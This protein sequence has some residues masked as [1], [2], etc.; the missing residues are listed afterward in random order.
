ME[1]W[2]DIETSHLQAIETVTS[3]RARFGN[4]KDRWPSTVDPAEVEA[5]D[6]A[7]WGLSYRPAELRPADEE[8]REW[9]RLA[10]ALNT[11]VDRGRFAI[12]DLQQ[13]AAISESLGDLSMSADTHRRLVDEYFVASD[14]Q[15]IDSMMLTARLDIA[16]GMWREA[17]DSANTALASALASRDAARL[18]QCYR[19]FSELYRELGTADQARI[20]QLEQARSAMDLGDASQILAAEIEGIRVDLAGP[21][22][23]AVPTRLRKLLD[24]ED[25]RNNSRLHREL[26]YLSLLA[27]GRALDFGDDPANRAVASDFLAFANDPSTP[28]SWRWR[29]LWWAAALAARRGDRFAYQELLSSAGISLEDRPLHGE[30]G[31]LRALLIGRALDDPESRLSTHAAL[32]PVKLEMA[33]VSQYDVLV[34]E[35]KRRPDLESGV[36]LLRYSGRRQVVIDTMTATM[37]AHPGDRGATTALDHWLRTQVLG[38]LS[39]RSKNDAPIDISTIRDEI[40]GPG[41][42]LIAFL[43][44]E[45]V[46]LVIA[47]DRDSLTIARTP[48]EWSLRPIR[49]A[50]DAMIGTRPNR[51]ELGVS[52]N[53]KRLADRDMRAFG[54]ALLPEEIRS[55]LELWDAVAVVGSDLLI[56]P[57]VEALIGKGATEP[58]GVTHAIRH[59]PSIAAGRWLAKR[60]RQDA[61]ARRVVVLAAPTPDPNVAQEYRA[62]T[63]LDLDKSLRMR[64]TTAS[65]QGSLELLL[66]NDATDTNLFE[67]TS[68][69]ADLA[70]I[71]AHGIRDKRQLRP[72]GVLLSPGT[73]NG[74][75]FVRDLE[76]WQCPQTVVL[77]TCGGTS[78]PGRFGDEGIQHLG[79]ALFRG[80]ANSIAASPL[81]LDYEA[82]LALLEVILLETTKGAPLPRALQRARRVVRENSRFDHPS[83]YLTLQAYGL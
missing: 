47:I 71:V 26:E 30:E 53:E 80:G 44:G 83:L 69:T 36:G 75:V 16:R 6:R 41:E 46:T 19:L 1:P 60:H 63:S 13:I 73:G 10:A 78:G 22:S 24:R 43:P 23:R 55:R 70:C 40:L 12:G 31:Q 38:S 56:S 27:R 51:T 74:T 50:F 48:G 35:W 67:S 15:R 81:E 5:F 57:F 68:V 72:A 66:G 2:G 28:R 20:F 61:P 33:L 45:S 79:G 82:T 3:L 9:W 62:T 7:L 17:L 37:L 76:R 11:A 39:P 59:L 49:E 34:E 65:K 8:L 29:A 64:L 18:P 14:P 52:E 21:N 54:A 25:V 32:D 42:G 4:L 77:A 58:L